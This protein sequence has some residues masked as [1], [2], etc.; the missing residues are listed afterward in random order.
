[1]MK[2]ELLKNPIYVVYETKGVTYD[3]YTGLNG[4]IPV[5]KYKSYTDM[6]DAWLFQLVKETHNFYVEEYA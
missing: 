2:T 5:A 4:A 6:V 3:P 1:M